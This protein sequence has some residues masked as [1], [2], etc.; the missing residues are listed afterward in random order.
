MRKNILYKV[1]ILGITPFIL[2]SCLVAKKYQTPDISAENLAYKADSISGDTLSIA[3]VKWEELFNDQTLKSYISKS[4][5]NNFD[6][7]VAIKQIDIAEAYLKQG[8]MGYYPT[9]NGNLSAGH[10]ELSKNSQMGSFFKNGIDNFELSVGL[11]W[12]AD[13]WGKIRSQKRAMEANYLY[14]QAARQAVQTRLIANVASSYYQLVAIDQQIELTK[15]TIET[16]NKSVETMTAL[17][18]AGVVNAAAVKQAEAQYYNAHII[19]IDLEKQAK[20]VENVISIL[21]GE[22]PHTIE[23]TSLDNQVISSDLKVGVPSQLLTNRPD[24]LMAEYKYRN[25]FEMKNVARSLYYPSFT[26]SASGGFQSIDFS[27]FLNPY[28]LFANILGGL[29]QPIFNQRKIR[30]QNEVASAQQEQTLIQFEQ[31]FVNASKEVSDALYNYES[32]SEKLQFQ[33]K[34]VESLSLAEEYA[35]E[36]LNNGLANYLEVLTA[37]ENVLNAKL[38]VTNLKLTQLNAMVELYRALG[39]GK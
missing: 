20:L 16:R 4:L 9:I 13:I 30:T 24:V 38:A 25:A 35:Q 6:V 17:Q 12:E 1:I 31:A 15:E 7:R 27:K 37:Q 32:A 19:L 21:L 14:S 26:L 39:G 34:M 11:S 29:T 3:G 36:L 5:E 10:Q 28:S 33:D 18:E 22:A 8:K 23:R 2:S